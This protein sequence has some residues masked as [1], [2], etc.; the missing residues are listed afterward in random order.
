M[1]SKKE[2]FARF[3]MAAKG[4]VY[5]LL[6][7]LTALSAFGMGGKKTGSKGALQFL[8]E[9]SYGKI[10]LIIMGIGL[11][12]YVF[13]RFYQSFTDPENHDNDFKGVATRIAYFISGLFYGGLAFYSFQ[14]AFGSGSSGSGGNNFVT[15]IFSSENGKIFAIILGILLT[16]KSIYEFYMAYSEKFKKD[17]QNAGL[18]SDVQDYLLKWG[19]FGFTSRGVVVGIMAFLTFRAAFKSQ[20]G[21]INTKTDALSYIQNEFGSLVLGIIAIGL[22]GYGIFMFIKA[23]YPSMTIR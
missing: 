16:V 20:G 22:V 14:L 6:G 1:S 11:L 2:N 17:I 10:V 12:G 19:R 8:A 3:G 13:C 4:A 5:V 18:S 23:K 21:S 7:I 9:Q 15:S